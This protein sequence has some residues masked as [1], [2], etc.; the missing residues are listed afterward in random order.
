MKKFIA[1]ACVALA[2]TTAAFAGTFPVD[3]GE[4]FYNSESSNPNTKFIDGAYSAASGAY[5]F[6]VSGVYMSSFD[7]YGLDSYSGTAYSRV[8]ENAGGELLFEYWFEIV[9]GGDATSPAL[10]AT[11]GGDWMPYTVYEVGSDGT[12]NASFGGWGSGDADPYSMGRGAFSGSPEINFYD[13]SSGEGVGFL[14]SV[15]SDMSA[16]FWYATDAVDYTADF[17]TLQGRRFR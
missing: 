16:H 11:I 8:W 9:P 2:A 3:P 5:T 1:F 12:G 10:R 14:P 6:N 7:S 4:F 17:I 13:S 15:G